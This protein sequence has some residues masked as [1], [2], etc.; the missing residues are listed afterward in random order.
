MDKK[1]LRAIPRPEATKKIQNLGE[2][3]RHKNKKSYIATAVV[4]DEMLIINIFEVGPKG[5][6]VLPFAR[7]FFTEDDYITQDL[8]SEKT[9]WKTGALQNFIGWAW[10]WGNKASLTPA[11]K[12]DKTTIIKWCKSYCDKRGKKV[13]GSD[14]EDY[15]DRYQEDIRGRKLKAK[16]DKERA[17]IDERMKL[18]E[19]EPDKE[20]FEEWVEKEAMFFHNFV[21][22]D[23]KNKWGY[24]TRCKHE[25]IISSDGAKV[26]GMEFIENHGGK[27]R[28]NKPYSCPFCQ[29]AEIE[30]HEPGKKIQFSP[31]KSIG[32]SR[33]S[34]T[35]IQWVTV[36]AVADDNGEKVITIRYISVMKDYRKDFRNPKISYF[37]RYRTIQKAS[38]S[39]DYE[40]EYDS[41]T[42]KV[43]WIPEKGRPYYWNPS[44]AIY[45]RNGTIPYMPDEMFYKDT[46]ARYCCL[47]QFKKMYELETRKDVSAW[48]IDQY[49]N[50]FRK[51]PYIEKIIKVGWSKLTEQIVD[52][53]GDSWNRTEIKDLL[54]TEANTLPELLGLT[55]EN[56]LLLKK[57]TNNPCWKDIQILIY[58][59]QLR[60]RLSEKDYNILRYFMDEGYV[61][62]W[63]RL[64]ECKKYSTLNKLE[65]YIHQNTKGR[66]NDYFD[67]L[68]WTGKL[69]YDMKNEFNLF[70]KDF[71]K[72]HDERSKEYMA[73]KDRL[74]REAV[75]RFNKLL[76][77]YKQETLDVEALNMNI[78]GLFIRL[79]NDLKELTKEGEA[80]HHC[81]GTYKEKVMKGETT[82]FFI[83]KISQPDKPFYTLEWKEGKVVQCRGMKN[84]SMTPEVKAF[85]EIFKVKML[86]Y[87]KEQMKI[88][89][90]S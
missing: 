87:E 6:K 83:R 24:C 76:K 34:L 64:L 46:W 4:S 31:A 39:E 82:I 48:F 20:T 14:I 74:Q 54:N 68:E 41:K 57:V 56:F 58:S 3:I 90:V 9:V 71:G 75:K 8:Q 43:C 73:Q 12:T 61:D 45:P 70:P 25:L 29:G 49:L 53:V 26:K 79:P 69:G 33:A 32:M 11:S 15:I 55:R 62:Q 7:S 72:S 21:I 23:W 18:F 77:R 1:S 81:V 28:H 37:E 2:L 86:A 78:D 52:G 89:M 67:Y 85:V 51:N 50:F 84:C 36:P 88:R 59:Q 13:I 22:Y 38:G 44:E 19:K 66:S 65:R 42:E 10:S 5:E 40:W 60:E 30:R 16:H 17:Q 63:K 27:P 47:E 80:L 35:E